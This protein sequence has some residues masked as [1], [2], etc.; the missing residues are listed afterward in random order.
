M[1]ASIG[2]QKAGHVLR[3]LGARTGDAIFESDIARKSYK[4]GD[5]SDVTEQLEQSVVLPNSFVRSEEKR[6][7]WLAPSDHEVE[8][9]VI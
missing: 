1:S 5:W 2:T 8:R 9:S 6:D 4:Y 7:L 3:V